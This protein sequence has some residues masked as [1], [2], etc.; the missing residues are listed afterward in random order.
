MDIAAGHIM[1]FV[2]ILTRIGAFF[3]ASPLFSWQA[4][5]I[6]SKVT[7]ALILAAF[8]A[9]MTPF[10]AETATLNVI[11]ATIRIADETFYGLAMGLV[12]Y[13]LMAVIRVAGGIIEQQVGLTMA[14]VM[15]PFSGEDGQPIGTLLE[16]IFVMLLF[17][18]DSHHLLLQILS[19]SFEGYAAGTTPTAGT[20]VESVLKAGSAMMMLALKLSAPILGAFLLLM[21]VLAFMAR[22]APE[23]NILFLSM[24]LRCGLGLLMVGIFLPFMAAYL[25][26]FTEWME[27]LIP[28]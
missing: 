4:I 27:R 20:L 11:E 28:L 18:T 22:V 10:P 23:A 15:D 14:S 21:V 17:V 9:A 24:P 3:A 19:R 25:K 2:L 7:I 1:G 12:A 26:Q 16:I 6:Q 5:P 13:S 8:F